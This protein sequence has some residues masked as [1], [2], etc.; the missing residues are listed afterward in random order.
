[1]GPDKL[2]YEL[3]E[4]VAICIVASERN[5]L[6]LDLYWY[7]FWAWQTMDTLVDIKRQI[8]ELLA[9]NRYIP[10]E[11]YL[12]EGGGD[13]ILHITSS[14]LNVNADSTKPL[15][16]IFTRSSLHTW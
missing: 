8:F 4:R 2:N 11:V 6:Q 13:N 3:I 12:T 10:L 15:K 16:A 1:M 9:G 14:E 7:S 5:L